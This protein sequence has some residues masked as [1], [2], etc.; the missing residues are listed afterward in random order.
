MGPQ[1]EVI[2]KFEGNNFML[3]KFKVEALLKARELQELVNGEKMKLE[4]DHAAKFLAYEKKVLNLFIQ[5][6]FDNW[7]I[8]VR[9]ETTIRG[10]WEA[11]QK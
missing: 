7:F 8:N 10:I 1:Y 3:W 6:L 2:E 5:G 4:I 11:F 9:K